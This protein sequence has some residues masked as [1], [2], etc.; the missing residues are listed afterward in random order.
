LKGIEE[1][2]SVAAVDVASG[3]FLHDFANRGLDGGAAVGH[4]ELEK[5]P[6]SGS[7]ARPEA[8]GRVEVAPGLP[9]ES[10][11]SAFASDGF[12]VLALGNHACSFFGHEKRRL[13]PPVCFV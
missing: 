2:A 4:G 5:I 6:D 8:L 1:L 3:E 7:P 12:H 13:S 9:F 11:R 10:R